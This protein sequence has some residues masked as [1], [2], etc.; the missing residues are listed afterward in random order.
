VNDDSLPDVD[1]LDEWTFVVRD[2]FILV[3]LSLNSLEVIGDGG[4]W[5][6]SLVLKTREGY[7]E[8]QT[9]SR[10]EQVGSR[11]EKRA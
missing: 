9:E 3:C 1:D 2:L 5:V 6:P 10:F 8:L 11:R 4:F 7:I